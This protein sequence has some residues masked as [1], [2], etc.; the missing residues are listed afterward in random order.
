MDERLGNARVNNVSKHPVL[1][2]SGLFSKKTNYQ[3]SLDQFTMQLKT[4]LGDI[5]ELGE[6]KP[7]KDG[8]L[9]YDY[10]KL[11]SRDPLNFWID[12]KQKYDM[13][14]EI[15]KVML[16]TPAQGAGPERM[17]SSGKRVLGTDRGS[18][19]GKIAGQL[20]M[21]YHRARYVVYSI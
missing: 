17:H 14:F 8:I 12:N 21:S 15:A 13:L 18:L 7:D 4:Y 2:N 6:L 5:A 3:Q 19:D 9:Y 11:L 1:E 10:F 16:A 20:T